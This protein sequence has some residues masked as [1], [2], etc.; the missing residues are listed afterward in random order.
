MMQPTAPSE[1]KPAMVA[2]M[3]PTAQS[4]HK[5]AT[6]AGHET[7]RAVGTQTSVVA[8]M[9]PTESDAVGIFDFSSQNAVPPKQEMP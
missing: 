7:D 3:K 5:P 6:V 2:D 8:D 9:K 4:E 1:H